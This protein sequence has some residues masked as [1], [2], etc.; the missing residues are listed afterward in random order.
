MVQVNI[1]DAMSNPEYFTDII[2]RYAQVGEKLIIYMD[3]NGTILWDDT[4]MCLGQEEVLLST[5]FGCIEVRPWASFAFAWDTQR[6]VRL[7]LG[8]PKTLKQLVHDLANGDMRFYRSFW[9]SASCVR[10]LSELAAFGETRWT[11]SHGPDQPPLSPEGFSDLFCSYMEEMERQVVSQG[12]TASWFKCLAMLREGG[13]SV[14]IQSFGMDTHRVVR[15]SVDNERKVLHIAVNIE[16]WSERDTKMF[17]EQ[18]LPAD[19]AKR[20]SKATTAPGQCLPS[21]L[22]GSWHGPL[23]W[24]CCREEELRRC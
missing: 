15:N 4:I 13:H 17:A 16:L 5:M 22:W 18:F 1:L 21:S 6:T 19:S 14:V 8:K 7:E 20:S 3:V 9:S 12:M 24:S 2:K 23:D 10:L 11:S